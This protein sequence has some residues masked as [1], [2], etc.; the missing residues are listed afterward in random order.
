MM[1]TTGSRISAG[2]RLCTPYSTRH[3]PAIHSETSSCRICPFSR[4][5]AASIPA[6]TRML[7]SITGI[8][9]YLIM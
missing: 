2:N 3:T 5:F 6:S 1:A 9:R 7:L 8:N 4:L